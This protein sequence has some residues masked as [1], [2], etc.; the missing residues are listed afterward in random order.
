[1]AGTK[2]NTEVLELSKKVPG[3]LEEVIDLFN[4][5]SQSVLDSAEALGSPKFTA[6]ANELKAN[7]DM[8]VKVAEELKQHTEEYN[9]T[10][11][12]IQDAF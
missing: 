9:K 10:Y 4:K 3:A 6:I 8:M 1:M 7:S 2:Y 12:N 11:G 5:G